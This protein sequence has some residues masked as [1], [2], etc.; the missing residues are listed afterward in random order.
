MR[1]KKLFLVSGILAGAAAASR[2]LSEDE[3]RP[4]HGP[5]ARLKDRLR[6]GMERML[7]G[8]PEGSP[9]RLIMST[10][11]SLKEQNEEILALLR[12]QNALLR[13]IDRRR[14]RAK[15]S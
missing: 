11:P 1:M 15:A 8:M 7:D 2:I 14:H 12:E 9:P 10:L 5:A 13:K 4:D 3:D 6:T